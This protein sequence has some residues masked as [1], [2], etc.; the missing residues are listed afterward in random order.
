M[1][2][3]ARSDLVAL[4]LAAMATGLL[5]SFLQS[6]QST[7][8]AV[9][10]FFAIPAIPALAAWISGPWHSMSSRFLF[11]GV[12]AVAGMAA[13]VV[14]NGAFDEA[15]SASVLF[16]IVWAIPLAILGFLVVLIADTFLRLRTQLRKRP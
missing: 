12:A 7:L 10:A 11:R 1:Y 14:A 15:E 4:A 3:P 9:A 5:L 16:G 6:T 8:V 2:T 13:V